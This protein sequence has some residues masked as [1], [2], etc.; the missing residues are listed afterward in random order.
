MS[1]RAIK[2]ARSISNSTAL[3]ILHT[4]RKDYNYK[5]Q[6]NTEARSCAVACRAVVVVVFDVVAVVIDGDG[7]ANCYRQS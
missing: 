6:R 2:V 1:E 5:V 7:H 3:F 4:G